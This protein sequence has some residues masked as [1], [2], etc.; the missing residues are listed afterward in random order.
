MTRRGT[1]DS[2]VASTVVAMRAMATR[3]AGSATLLGRPP[4][5]RTGQDKDGF[6][7]R[8]VEAGAR[9][10]GAAGLRRAKEGGTAIVVCGC[11]GFFNKVQKL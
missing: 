7:E 11:L 8:S 6:E 4:A 3:N 5:G 9:V 2:V 1:P 10:G